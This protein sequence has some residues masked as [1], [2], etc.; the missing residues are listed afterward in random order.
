[1]LNSTEAY[2]ALRAAIRQLQDTALNLADVEVV[3][4]RFKAPRHPMH[5]FE[6][7]LRMNTPA[8]EQSIDSPKSLDELIRLDGIILSRTPWTK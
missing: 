1:M 3:E 5:E 2:E 4:I 6:R 7:K 8:I